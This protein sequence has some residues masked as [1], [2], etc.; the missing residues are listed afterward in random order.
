MRAA[1]RAAAWAAPLLMAGL[2]VACLLLLYRADLRSGGRVLTGELFDGRIADALQL[3]WS[4]VFAGEEAWNRPGYFY[5]TKDTLGFNDGYLLFGVFA[6]SFRAGG[7]DPFLAAELAGLP[8]RLAGFVGLYLFCREALGLA[9]A[10]ALLAA[11]VGILANNVHLQQGHEQ[12]LTVYLAPLEALLV[13]R[14]VAGAGASRT[15]AAVGYGVGAAILLSAWALTA[16]YMLWF[17]AWLAAVGVAA[18]FALD[19]R[20]FRDAWR[21]ASIAFPAVPLLA[22]AIGLV[23]FVLTY[24]PSLRLTGG[25]HPWIETFIYTLRPRDLVTVSPGNLVGALVGEAPRP[26]G[27]YSVGLPAGLW[28]LAALGVVVTAGSPRARKNAVRLPLALAA[29]LTLLLA[30]RWGDHT[31]WR[32]VA[33]LLPGAEAVRVVSRVMLLLGLVAAC[34]AAVGLEWLAARGV[35]GAALTGLAL[36]LVVE[37]VNTAGLAALPRA[38]ENAFL[39]RIPPPPPGCRAFVVTRPRPVTDLPVNGAA[40]ALLID[41]DAMLLAELHGVPTPLGDASFKPPDY[42]TT[43]SAAQAALLATGGR[44]S[45]CGVDL[46]AGR[47]AEM[48]PRVETLVPGERVSFG[49]AQSDAMVAGGWSP[50]EDGARWSIGPTPALIFRWPSRAPLVLHVLG[51]VGF[52]APQ[53]PDRVDISANGVPIGRW[54]NDPAP[55][56]RRLVVPAA[57]I[58]TDRLVRLLFRIHGAISP[59]AAGLSFD[60]RRLGVLIWSMAAD[61]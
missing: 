7:A 50:A 11:T 2:L 61:R 36:L 51:H 53:H 8:F 6:A 31:L 27:E 58:G 30:M 23:P 37:E 35:K 47:W 16:F 45:L 13:F 43:M 24:A 10:S 34:L 4:R 19:P 54:P 59:A 40:E 18:A 12:L 41:T 38:R 26:L 32:P 42:D 56:D 21:G 60:D 15:G 9:Q 39:A 28:L 57:A 20:R 3:H 17:T 22:A 55:A 44:W 29:I 25:T 14:A 33:A 1:R 48:A 49:A 46:A 52:G 5:P